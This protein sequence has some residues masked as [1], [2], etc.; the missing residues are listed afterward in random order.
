[1]VHPTAFASPGVDGE[2]R[3]LRV[4]ALRSR[5]SDLPEAVAE[6]PVARISMTLLKRVRFIPFVDGWVEKL[7]ASDPGHLPFVALL[8]LPL[9]RDDLVDVEA[10]LLPQKGEKSVGVAE[11]VATAKLGFRR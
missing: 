4:D 5:D 9:Q 6:H 11:A 1:M 7:L 3:A 8:H 2:D 10:G